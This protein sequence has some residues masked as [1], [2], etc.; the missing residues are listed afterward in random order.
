MTP[1]GAL[2]TSYSFCAQANCAD[3]TNPVAGLVLGTDGNFYGVT[4]FGGAN[5]SG[6][7]FQLTP[8][9]TLN[10]LYTFCSQTNCADGEYP[11]ATLIQATDGN[12][13]GT[14]EYGGTGTACNSGAGCGTIF[15]ITPSGTLTV[16]YSFNGNDGSLP[17]GALI[18]GSDGSFYGTTYLGGANNNGTVFQMTPTGTLTTLHSFGGADGARPAAG[19]V[20][21]KDGNFYATTS[22]G[23]AKGYGT[24]FRITPGG[25]LTTLHSFNRT[26]GSYPISG[27]IQATDGNLYG[28]TAEGANGYGTIFG[29]TPGGRFT[30]LYRFNSTDGF[31]NSG[32]VQANDGTFYGTSYPD[33]SANDGTIFSL[34]VGLKPF[35][36]MLPT[37]GEV[38]KVIRI[39]GTDLNGATS[40]S[41]N[42]TAAGPII[43]SNTEITATV[44]AG[45]TTGFVTVTTPTRTLKSNVNFQVRP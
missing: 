44:P 43:V 3:G 12:F 34:S 45:A 40:V 21:G 42:G 23:G 20:Q 17:D 28:T 26:G 29:I 22:E 4:E 27:L 32:L 6:T 7:V 24:V 13:Y 18:Q 8:T 39:L 33:S 31:G 35:V 25:T 10:T 19:L 15:K 37:F 5:F 30:T 14:T 41:F 38:G 1:A 16:L 11:L 2:N 9:G 36:E